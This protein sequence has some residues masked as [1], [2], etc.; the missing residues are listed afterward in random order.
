[1]GSAGLTPTAAESSTTHRTPGLNCSNFGVGFTDSTACP[2]TGGPTSQ[3][4]SAPAG[5]GSLPHHY[6]MG[7][8]Y[9]WVN[10]NIPGSV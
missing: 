6:Q 9:F 3:G 1:M 10:G 8:H 5:Q 7:K 2:S 4:F